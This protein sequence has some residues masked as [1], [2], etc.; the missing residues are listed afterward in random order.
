M[1][2]KTE[3]IEFTLEDE[4]TILYSADDDEL[5][6]SA[7]TDAELDLYRRQF[8]LSLRGSAD[9]FSE[10]RWFSLENLR[11]DGIDA[12]EPSL[13]EGIER[14]FLRQIRVKWEGGSHE[15]ITATASG[16]FESA[17]PSSHQHC[18]IPKQGTLQRA[19]FLIQF[20]DSTPWR[21]V[22]ICLPD[23]L[24]LQRPSDLLAVA[25]WL[26]RR[27]LCIPGSQL[28]PPVSKAA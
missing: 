23:K 15:V 28:T 24:K 7:R 25:R 14:T 13:A 22:K 8:G 10:A 4:E 12:L 1:D 18:A 19:A 6:I 20:T 21:A 11:T 16:V 27:G 5:W 17:N 9:Y 2:E 3:F 26:A